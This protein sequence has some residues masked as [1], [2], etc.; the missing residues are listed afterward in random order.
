MLWYRYEYAVNFSGP[1]KWPKKQKK[2]D[3]KSLALVDVNIDTKPPS[4]GFLY[5]LYE[6]AMTGDSLTK[7]AK[8]ESCFDKSK[9]GGIDNSCRHFCASMAKFIHVECFERYK[10]LVKEQGWY[11]AGV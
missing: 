7:W 9:Y 3:E 11:C 5:E 10:S 1:A 4:H 2:A 6:T 8:D